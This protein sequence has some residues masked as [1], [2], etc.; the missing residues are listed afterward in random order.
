MRNLFVTGAMFLLIVAGYYLGRYLYLK[1]ENIVGDRA[2]EIKGKLPDGSDFALTDLRGYYVLLDFWG[3]WCVPCRE[4]H[5]AMVELYD[6]ISYLT[7]EDA[8]GFEIVSIGIE[9][10]QR[11]WQKAIQDDNLI[12]PFHLLSL[13]DFDEPMIK[14]YTV[15]QIPTKFLINPQGYIMAVD[16]TMDEVT[17]LLESRIKREG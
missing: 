13:G 1:P 12:W 15:K 8:K 7:M 10:N 11:H 9:Q 6:R 5:P 16:P 2:H 17:K 3:S 14:A 4:A